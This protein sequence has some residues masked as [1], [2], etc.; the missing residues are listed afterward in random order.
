MR[1]SVFGCGNMG[2][3]VTKAIRNAD[4]DIEIYTYTP[5][6]SKAQKLAK[7]V[8]GFQQVKVQSMFPC[9]VMML[10]MKPQQFAQFA[11]SIQASLKEN[12]LV[13]S[14]LAGVEIHSI[15]QKLNTKRVI[16]LMPNT[17][18]LV[19]R[20]VIPYVTSAELNRTDKDLLMKW[21]HDSSKLITLQTEDQMDRVMA[22]SASGPGLLFEMAEIM[23]QKLLN[24]KLSE[25]DA[26][27]IVSEL[28]AG[29]GELMHSEH[30]TFAELRNRVTSKG[31]V[32]EASLNILNA[33]NQWASLLHQA[34]E[35]NYRRS[36][37]LK[38]L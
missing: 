27:L 6:G 3:A 13:I 5:S 32:T 24:D 14:L 15:E 2:S 9:D 10:G 22:I 19:G 12:T 26:R 11:E 25:K 20:G 18:T 33:N 7:S 4:N 1:L 30:E 29:T 35:A 38:N 36:N 31:G 21:L 17:P 37:E 23:Y 16:R 8:K 34:F 28:F